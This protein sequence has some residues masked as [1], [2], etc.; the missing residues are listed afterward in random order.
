MIEALAVLLMGPADRL[1]GGWLLQRN[2]IHPFH[3][4]PAVW[5][6]FVA[7]G[8]GFTWMALAGTLAVTTARIGYG[9]AA[10]RFRG[11][12]FTCEPEWYEFGSVFLWQHP[13]A[14]VFLSGFLHG[15]LIAVP[16]AVVAFACKEPAWFL[17]AIPPI[18]GL[19]FVL[20]EVFFKLGEPPWPQSWNGAWN[21]C[22]RGWLTG[23]MCLPL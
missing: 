2:P 22:Y 4:C 5:L 18:K 3:R 8:Q 19:G 1:R 15:C 7:L 13:A 9:C 11:K 20:S 14:S 6:M 10:A 23:L 17:A 12:D 21:E 16:A